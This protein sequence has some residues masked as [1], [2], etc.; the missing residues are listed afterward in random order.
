[1]KV[2]MKSK[3]PKA[4]TEAEYLTCLEFVFKTDSALRKGRLKIDNRDFTITRRVLDTP[5]ETSR[6]MDILSDVL[7]YEHLFGKGGKILIEGCSS[8]RIHDAFKNSYAQCRKKIL[9]YTERGFL[10]SEAA[11]AQ[12]NLNYAV[13]SEG[14]IVPRYEPLLKK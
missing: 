6:K 13:N 5:E 8:G 3:I 2:K 9:D 14:D 11:R 1:M 7:N 4:I 10:V 12:R